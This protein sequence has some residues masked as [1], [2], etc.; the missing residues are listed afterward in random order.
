MKAIQYIAVTG[1]VVSLL[2][3]VPAYAVEGTAEV[4]AYHQQKAADYQNKIAAQ[5]A[6]IAE[7]QQMPAEYRMRF[8]KAGAPVALR[9][10]EMHC[11][12]IIKDAQKLKVDLEESVHWHSMQAAELQGQ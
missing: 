8:P 2:A 7:H 1:M 9:K 3:A 5:D 6:I 11:D 4:V 12:T 10:M